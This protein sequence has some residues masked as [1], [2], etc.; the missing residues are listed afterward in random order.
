[1]AN[2]INLNNFNKGFSDAFTSTFLQTQKLG[3]QESQFNREM[4]FQDRQLRL[5]EGFR[6]DELAET[7]K[8][9]GMLGEYY[10]TQSEAE[11]RNFEQRQAEQ[12]ALLLREG[13]QQYDETKSPSQSDVKLHQIYGKSWIAPPKEPEEQSRMV[14]GA[15]GTSI[16]EKFKIDPTSG[17]EIITN[18]ENVIYPPTPT[19]TV[20][21]ERVD[22]FNAFYNEGSSYLAELKS[23]N[24][25]GG[26]EVGAT[27][28]NEAKQKA[29]L[30][31]QQALSLAFTSEDGTDQS[32]MILEAL[33]ANIAGMEN[34][35]PETRRALLNEAINQL[36][37]EY[38][39]S[40]EQL[41]ALKLWNEVG[42]R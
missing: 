5:I 7:A 8:Y 1:M 18:Y 2:V 23:I 27:Q 14:S 25:L 6:R 19:T 10:E 12:E 22:K 38:D 42:T 35:K 32:K 3:Q 33:R 13:W 31:S 36:D 39:L 41:K 29:I 28:Y 16:E 37:K 40:E 21:T 24:D 34:A 26:Q 4:S 9:H 20:N 15:Y 30:N 11:K 17:K